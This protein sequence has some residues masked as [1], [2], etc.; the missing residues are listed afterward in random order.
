MFK[1]LMHG[2]FYH[3]TDVADPK[4]SRHSGHLSP[5][6]GESGAAQH[7]MSERPESLKYSKAVR[8]SYGCFL[9][10]SPVSVPKINSLTL[11]KW[12]QLDSIGCSEGL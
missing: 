8:R 10:D 6:M 12:G 7:R 9:S 11:Q 1:E 2:G 3:L 5:Q 4:P